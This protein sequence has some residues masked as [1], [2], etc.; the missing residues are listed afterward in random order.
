MSVGP[1]P[2][3]AGA[4][5]ADGPLRVT[6]YPA[7]LKGRGGASPPNPNLVP[8][9]KV[10]PPVPPRG[11]GGATSGRS[12]IDDHRGNAS[13]SS[14]TTSGRGDPPKDAFNMHELTPVWSDNNIALRNSI[15]FDD[16]RRHNKNALTSLHETL[17]QSPVNPR[18][19]YEKND[20]FTRNLH[21]PYS[22]DSRGTIHEHPHDH[23]VPKVSGNTLTTIPLQRQ[24]QQPIWTNPRFPRYDETEEFVSVE[25]YNDNYIIRTS[26]SPFRPDRG[27]YRCAKA[28][29][30][31]TNDFGDGSKSAVHK[32]QQIYPPKLSQSR[33][34]ESL[35]KTVSVVPKIPRIN[36]AKPSPSRRHETLNKFTY[37]IN[38]G[39]N[40]YDKMSR[41]DKKHSETYAER[42]RR[43][44][45]EISLN[46]SG[47]MKVDVIRRNPDIFIR[48]S[49]LTPTINFTRKIEPSRENKPKH[50]VP[51]TNDRKLIRNEIPERTLSP[52]S[53]KLDKRPSRKNEPK[54]DYLRHAEKN[55]I[56]SNMSDEKM[57]ERRNL[58]GEEA[59]KLQ[60]SSLE[61]SLPNTRGK[62]VSV[63]R[64]KKRNHKIATRRSSR[65]KLSTPNI[66][67]D[68]K[69]HPETLKINLSDNEYRHYLDDTS[70]REDLTKKSPNLSFL[71]GYS[72]SYH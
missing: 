11:S 43:Q 62:R 28:S 22:I 30:Q 4:I 55:F 31:R 16:S 1:P 37:F 17:P 52:S 3:S 14:S 29:Q 65:M 49:S 53:I 18:L 23:I 40:V 48:P 59:K 46:S 47:K 56:I 38:P 7:V 57:V 44:E 9:G 26:P 58:H 61:T 13:S 69:V 15:G 54:S 10:P 32:I 5:T 41:K 68:D 42:M 72:S 64:V 67:M 2:L 36:L 45:Q 12:R 24:I 6:S 71:H 21:V 70:S 33:I 51:K 27:N 25:K 60:Q 20:I 39:G 35:G 19:S 63:E 66:R 50:E 34:D 8:S